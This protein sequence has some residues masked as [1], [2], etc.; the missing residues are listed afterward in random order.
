M[1]RT[2]R[3]EILQV[4]LGAPLALAACRTAEGAQQP[5]PPGDLLDPGRALG[6]ALFKDPRGAPREPLPAA[7]LP[8]CDVVIVGA[9]VAG[10]AA[11]FTLQQAGLR[12]VGCEIAEEVGGTSLSGRSPVS[13]YP[14][15]AH[16][17][18]APLREN[19]ALISFLAELGML[20]GTVTISTTRGFNA[21]LAV[22][23]GI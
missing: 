10:L 13:A 22:D 14:W 12:V 4:A 9:G 18:T 3:R 16:Y 1:L 8:P 11:A 2:T 23:A 5:L 7:R 17:I 21:Q 15:G 19:Q 6:H 20:D